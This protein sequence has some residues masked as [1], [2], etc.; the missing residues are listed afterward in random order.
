MPAF[1]YTILEKGARRSGEIEAMD[2]ASAAAQLQ[3][4]G[5][6]IMQLQQTAAKTKGKRQGTTNGNMER[7][8]RSMQVRKAHIEQVF[9]QLAQM[10]RAGVP[11]LTALQSLATHAPRTMRRVCA[12]LAGHVREGRA[13]HV[14][15]SKEAAFVGPITIG[16]VQAGENNGTLDE[17]L[18]YA[19]QLMEQRRKVRGQIMGALAY[20]LF[21]V[22]AA[23]G[24]GYYMVTSVIPQIMDFIGAKSPADLPRVTQY[25]VYTND[26]LQLYGLYIL[27]APVVVIALVVV[28]KRYPQTAV[29]VDEGFLHIPPIGKALQHYANALWCR[30]LGSL[31]KSGIDIMAALDLAGNTVGNASYRQRILR[32]KDAV[33]EGVSFPLAM[34]QAGLDKLCPMAGTMVAVS[35][36]SGGLDESLL[37][38]AD[39]SEEQLSLRV[40]LLSK[41]IEPAIFILVGGMVGFVYFG[42]FLAVLAATQGGMR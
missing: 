42:F 22:L 20:P 11:L 9:G 4:Q 31:V 41:M 2:Q 34:Q 26:F 14:A 24:L 10:L 36:Q 33:R 32:M 21:V 37:H 30:T 17:M 8:L 25:L 6:R 12:D 35:E 18:R 29:Q 40:A 3:R 5:A 15:L 23:F 28:A 27:L 19:A 16:L 7:L 38:A 39:F 13:L 1:T